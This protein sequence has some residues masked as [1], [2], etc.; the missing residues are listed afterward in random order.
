MTQSYEQSF[1]K[2]TPFGDL[3]DGQRK[4][5]RSGGATIELLRRGNKL[6]ARDG[7]RLLASRIDD[8]WAWVCLDGCEA[9]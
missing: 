1:R 7:E 5:F 2:I 8:G 9:E 3:P 4:T 6:E